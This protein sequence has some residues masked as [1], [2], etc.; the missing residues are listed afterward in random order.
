MNAMR[1]LTCVNTSVPTLLAPTHVHVA[2]D[3]AL[4]PIATA[5]SVSN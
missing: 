5:A 4:P 3:T 2:Q 1:A